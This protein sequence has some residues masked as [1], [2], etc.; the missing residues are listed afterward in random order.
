MDGIAASP[1]L[2]LT[3]YIQIL[4]QPPRACHGISNLHRVQIKMLNMARLAQMPPQ[5]MVMVWK[6]SSFGLAA[7]HAAEPWTRE[8]IPGVEC[9]WACADQQKLETN[10]VI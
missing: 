3:V 4:H 10:I 8:D 6:A 2:L 1:G 9:A 5:W 7:W